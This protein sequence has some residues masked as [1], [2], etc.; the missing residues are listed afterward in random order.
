[1]RGNHHQTARKLKTIYQNNYQARLEKTYKEKK[2][3]SKIWS[4]IINSGKSIDN[5]KRIRMTGKSG[6]NHKDTGVDDTN[7]NI[8]PNARKTPRDNNM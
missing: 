8:S 4:D 7:I 6:T 1:M 2:V 5:F 3:Q